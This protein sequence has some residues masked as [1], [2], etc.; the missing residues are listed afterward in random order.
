MKMLPLLMAAGWRAI[1][2]ALQVDPILTI[3]RLAA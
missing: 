3:R 2:Q 1:I